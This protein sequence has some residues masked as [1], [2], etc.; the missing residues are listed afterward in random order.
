[1]LSHELWRPESGPPVPGGVRTDHDA[2]GAG[3]ELPVGSAEQIRRVFERYRSV[4]VD[5]LI[6]SG[7]P[8]NP[9][10]YHRLDDEVLALFD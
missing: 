7:I 5:G 8:M 10:I 4:G 2:G 9:R 3:G 1:M 6:F